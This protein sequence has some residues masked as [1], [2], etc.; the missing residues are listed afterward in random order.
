MNWSDD[1]SRWLTAVLSDLESSRLFDEAGIPDSA[2]VHHVGRIANAT[3][4]TP[5]F[6]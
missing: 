2:I 3:T 4:A 6:E 1:G 5:G